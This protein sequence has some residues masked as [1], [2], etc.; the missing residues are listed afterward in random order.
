MLAEIL[1]VFFKKLLITLGCLVALMVP[2]MGFSMLLA[3]GMGGN[4]IMA[5]SGA[6]LVIL[7]VVVCQTVDHV[8]SKSENRADER[9]FYENCNLPRKL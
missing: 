8:K 2:I 1:K 3:G 4:T 6:G 7:F 5:L 9:K